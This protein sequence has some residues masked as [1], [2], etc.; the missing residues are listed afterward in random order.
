MASNAKRKTTMAKLNRERRLRE[1]RQEKQ[2][3][4]EARR[5]AS[6]DDLGAAGDAATAAGPALPD[7]GGYAPGADAPGGD[8]LDAVVEAPADA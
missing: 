3:K 6:G 5:Q 4:K 2:A 1:R 7:P 8:A